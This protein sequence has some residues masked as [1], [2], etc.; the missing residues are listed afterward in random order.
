[1]PSIFG[2]Y[3]EKKEIQQVI[4]KMP[5]WIRWGIS[6]IFL[7]VAIIFSTTWL[8]EY[9]DAVEAPIVI[10]A[11][12]APVRVFPEKIGIIDSI[13][14]A[15]G[16]YI[17]EGRLL[18][19]L[20]TPGDW[21]DILNLETDLSALK[22]AENID[23]KIKTEAK[24]G[25]LQDAYAIF[26]QNLNN[27]QYFIK[28]NIYRQRI[29][30]VKDRVQLI[31]E[32]ISALGQQVQTADTE[33]GITARDLNRNE[34]MLADGLISETDLENKQ[35]NF[36]RNKRQNQRLESEIIQH[37]ITINELNAQVV[38]L[39]Q[40]LRDEEQQQRVQLFTSVDI[41][42]D[43]IRVWKQAHLIYAPVSG[44]ISLMALLRPKMRVGPDQPLLTLVPQ[45]DPSRIEGLASVG[46]QNFGKI[47]AG[48]PVKVYLESFPHEQYGV[49]EGVV[50]HIGLVPQDNNYMIEISFPNQ[51][52]TSYKLDL[53][54]KQEMR[55]QAKIIV[56]PKRLI[57]RLTEQIIART[58]L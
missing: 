5:G 34:Q 44:R 25:I 43:R 52:R 53:P 24:L 54:F 1:M 14:V 18:A 32:L 29:T 15:E 28:N 49:L 23:F 41:L 51:L 13:L 40:S 31:R 16:Q 58:E 22:Q 37:Q 17:E 50:E 3:R 19:V 57:Q 42:R 7:A 11:A 30:A 39:G 27:Y 35:V 20:Q 38:E 8:L 56:K 45:E 47:E 9:S 33:L 48:M 26:L 2:E 4:G 55:G 12:N 46:G 10:N 36:Y 6:V 21:R